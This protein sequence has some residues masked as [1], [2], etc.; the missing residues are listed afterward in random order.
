MKRSIRPVLSLAALFSLVSFAPTRGGDWPMWGGRPDRNMVSPEKNLPAA[1]GAGKNIKW[2]AELGDQTWGN[3]VVT[4]GRVFIGTNNGKPRNP[5]VKGD[6]GVLMCLSAEDGKFQW[7]AVHEKLEAGDAEDWEYIGIC[8]TPCVVGDR[9]YYVSNRAELVCCDAEGFLDGENDGPFKGEKLT[10]KRDADIVWILD[11]REDLGIRPYQASA[12]S[13]LVVG[14]LVFAVTGQGISEETHKVKDPQAPSFVAVD[15]ST[16][17]VVWQDNSPGE[18]ILNGQWASPAYGVVDGQAQVAFPGGD[19]WLYAFEPKAGKLLWKF[20]CKAHEK[21]SDEGKPETSNHLLATPVYSGNRVLIAVGDNPESNTDANGCLRAIDAR[22]RGDVTKSAELWRVAGEEFTSSISNVAARDGRVYAVQLRGFLDCF[23]SE[24]GKRLWQ[25]DFLTLVW[26]SPLVADGKVYVRTEEGD[27]FVFQEG[28]K[29][30]ILATNVLP[31][32]ANGTVVASGGVLYVAG[33][34][35][36][37]A[38]SRKD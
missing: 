22:K 15:R 35:R 9:V 29:K 37:Y 32:L 14:D 27:T 20:N 10:G 25:H 2:I 11:M 21:V 12:S 6:R 24:S 36:L 38:I 16:G 17:K 1:W 34:T 8:S 26:G 19:G 3:P 18:R 33:T 30:K 4:G 13:P 28:P 31:S 7:Q 5:A 23:D